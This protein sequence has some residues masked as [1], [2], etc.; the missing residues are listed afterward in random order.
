MPLATIVLLLSL[1]P[2][3]QSPGLAPG[4][5]IDVLESLQPLLEDF[6]CEYEG[7]FHFKGEAA[8]RSL[9]VG[10]GGLS[11]T[12]SGVF[13][14]KRDGDTRG[15][16]FHRRGSDGRILREELAVRFTKGEAEC[17][18][19]DNDAPLGKGVIDDP[20]V[21]NAD[22]SGCLGGIFFLEGIKRLL[23][24][25]DFEFKITDDAGGGA[26]LKLLTISF[27]GNAQLYQRLWL[28]LRRGGHMVLR[29]TYA[30]KGELI[31]GTDVKLSPVKFGMETI[32]MPVSGR[33][34]GHSALRGKEPYFPKEVTSVQQ[35]DIVAG[36]LEFNKR[37]APSVFR[38]DYK[39]GTL[40][41]DRLRKAQAEFGRQVPT[42]LPSKAE[43]EAILRA[44]LAE[45]EAQRSELVAEPPTAFGASLSPWLVG[46]AGTSALV[47]SIVVLYQRRR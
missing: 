10:E 27:K 47:L 45:A 29:E 3:G 14:W 35:I 33:S 41:S 15:S 37:P 34:E 46:V 25:P 6:R 19:R 11:D 30:A 31:E 26:A 42:R 12:F 43:T 23:A 18:E 17:Y 32:W 38:I 21:V 1:L 8:K 44:Q 22:Q 16:T 2:A 36:T 7:T 13:I 20:S 4:S 5:L 40:I 39:P 28:D 9:E 24:S